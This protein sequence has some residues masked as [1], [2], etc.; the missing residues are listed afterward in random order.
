[1]ERYESHGKSSSWVTIAKGDSACCP[2]WIED[3]TGKIQ[4]FPNKAETILNMDFEFTTG[5][6][7]ELPGNLIAFMDGN[8]IAWRSFF[9]TQ[10]LRFREWNVLSDEQAF[11][12]GTAGKNQELVKQHN[13]R[14]YQRLMELKSRPDFEK[15]ADT[16]QDGFISDEEWDAVSAKVEQDVLDEELKSG[17]VQN[18]DVIIS[19]GDKNEV[20][21]ISDESQKDLEAKLGWQAF[22]G[23]FGG[24]VLTL[25]CLAYLLWR[26]GH[27]GY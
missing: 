6:G 25:I 3:S 10:T 18:M 21:I 12:L 15:M 9:G 4:V 11:V 23:V 5:W 7:R 16:N 1:V 27:T 8:R 14:C 19:K 17:Q 13:D 20:F 22:S 24:A 26:F 2:F